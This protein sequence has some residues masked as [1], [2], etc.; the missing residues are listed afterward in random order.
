MPR[1]AMLAG[2]FIKAR[3]HGSEAS[4]TVWKAGSSTARAPHTQAI[5]AGNVRLW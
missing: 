5:A 4:V 1:S 3:I 2:A